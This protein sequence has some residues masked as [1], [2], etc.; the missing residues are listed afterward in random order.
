MPLTVRDFRRLALGMTGAVEGAHMGHPDFRVHGRIFASLQ[1]GMR[2]GMVVLT[3]EQQQR[4]VRDDPAAFMP[5][6]GAWGRAGYTRVQL[7]RV[8]E[9]RLG[10][11]LTLAFQHVASKTA[12]KSTAAKRAQRPRQDGHAARKGRAGRR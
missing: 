10:E 6:S 3:P 11:A 8:D 1:P 9:E 5:E 12:A 2:T 7:D 4:F